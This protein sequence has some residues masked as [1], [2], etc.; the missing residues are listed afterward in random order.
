VRRQ[1]D[2]EA[3]QRRGAPFD[4]RTGPGR[5]TA[6]YGAVPVGRPLWCRFGHGAHC[7]AGLARRPA[8]S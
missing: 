2:Q 5:F 4:V 3:R 6:H 8:R 7:G 1:V